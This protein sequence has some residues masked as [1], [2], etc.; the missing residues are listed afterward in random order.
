MRHFLEHRHESHISTGE[1]LKYTC[2]K[3]GNKQYEIGEIWAFSSFLAKMFQIHN[4]RFTNITCK[5]CRYT[6][7]YK[8]PKKRIG[9]IINFISR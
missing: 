4:C 3:C 2:P 1:I 5:N 8:V 7:L 6:E 9:E